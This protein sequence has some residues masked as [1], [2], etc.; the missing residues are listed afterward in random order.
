MPDNGT[1]QDDRLAV[2]CVKGCDSESAFEVVGG[3]DHF[4]SAMI[5]G[6]CAFH[7]LVVVDRMSKV[8]EYV[9]WRDRD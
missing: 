8:W 7:R 1:Y 4:H 9:T 6:A 2:C 5:G 3:M